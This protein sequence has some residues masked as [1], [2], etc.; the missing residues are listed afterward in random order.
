MQQ[1]LSF[2][3][4][5][6]L[7]TAIFAL[8][9]FSLDL[10]IGWCGLANFG[11]IAFLLIG[12]YT[13]AI[14]TKDG[15]PPWLAP[16]VSAL[17]GGLFGIVLSLTVRNMS[18]TYWGM[19]SLALAELVRLFF[20]NEQWV[21]GGAGGSSVLIHLPY[22]GPLVG[23]SVA[24]V[25]VLMRGIGR[26]PFGRVIR[27]I[28]EGDRLPMALGKPVFVFKLETML[29]GGLI[30]GLAGSY[31]A[32]L[33]RYISP[34]DG[35]PIETFVLWAMVILGGRGNPA[36]VVLGTVVVQALYVGTEYAT[37][38][39]QIRPEVLFALRLVLI[40]AI[41]TLVMVFRPAGLL[42]E[43]RRVYGAAAEGRTA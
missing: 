34:A 2:A 24:L 30:G 27:L 43:R 25:Y 42:P 39:I 35:L 10:Q 28:R 16:P 20:L 26:S 23:I 1:L 9:S 6:A 4:Y 13:T 41:I 7:S 32:F 18:A 3:D 15:L 33:N 8:L 22:F 37:T 40:G 38:L 19:L 5:L 31:Y 17:A 12:G 36:G 29:I 11:Q 14:A 21:G